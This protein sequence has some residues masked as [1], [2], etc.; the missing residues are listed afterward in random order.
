MV[1]E[2][3]SIDTLSILLAVINTS[4]SFCEYLE[5]R[6]FIFMGVVLDKTKGNH[7]IITDIRVMG[8]LGFESSLCYAIK[9]LYTHRKLFHLI[10]FFFWFFDGFLAACV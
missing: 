3:N 7:Q 2:T 9:I 4:V 6:A 1:K 10:S 8:N 5:Q